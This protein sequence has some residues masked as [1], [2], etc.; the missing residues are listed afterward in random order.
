MIVWNN[1]HYR[2]WTTEAFWFYSFPPVEEAQMNSGETSVMYESSIFCW[3]VDIY[4]FILVVRMTIDV[5]RSFSKYT[6]PDRQFWKRNK[7]NNT[8]ISDAIPALAA[9]N[10]I[11]FLLKLLLHKVLILL[12]QM[13][14]IASLD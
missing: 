4:L 13:V 14:L 9:D 2:L 1:E 10:C 5:N 3:G 8:K 11:L 7:N 6:W 12:Y